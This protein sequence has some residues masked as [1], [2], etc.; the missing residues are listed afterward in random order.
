MV[1][2]GSLDLP[3]STWCA[4]GKQ[5]SPMASVVDKQSSDGSKAYLVRFRIADGKQRSLRRIGP[6][7]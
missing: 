3:T 4:P 6:S 5:N 7:M 1:G 2:D